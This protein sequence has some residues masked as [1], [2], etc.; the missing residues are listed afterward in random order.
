MIDS[1]FIEAAKNI[2]AEFKRLNEELDKN[3]IT[4]DEVNSFL[5]D[6]VNELHDFEDELKSKATSKE[7][8]V[9]VL[10][11]LLKK[12]QEIEKMETITTQRVKEVTKQI[13]K[14]QTE[15]NN[16]LKK[17]RESYPEMTLDEIRIEVHSH[18]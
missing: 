10:K 6:K 9:E 16:L 7:A 2:R 12:I 15:E 1:K 3:Q 11:K 18:L 13:E 5:K 4:V 17:I 8:V 14:L